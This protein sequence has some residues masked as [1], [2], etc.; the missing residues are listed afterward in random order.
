MNEPVGG[1]S[2]EV[3]KNIIARC[4]LGLPKNFQETG[5]DLDFNDQQ[6]FFRHAKHLQLSWWDTPYFEELV[7]ADV[8]D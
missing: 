8:L 1:G 3:Q 5:M 6:L 7:A 2:S 4:H